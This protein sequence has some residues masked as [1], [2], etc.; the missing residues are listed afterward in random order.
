MIHVYREGFH[1]CGAMIKA[2]AT[3]LPLAR[4]QLF[5]QRTQSRD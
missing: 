5:Y 1:V 2:A 4:V 3:Y